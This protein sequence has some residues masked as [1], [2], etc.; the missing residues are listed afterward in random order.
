MRRLLTN[1]SVV[2]QDICTT[3]K[4]K[5]RSHRPIIIV[6]EQMP[7]RERDTARQFRDKAQSDYTHRGWL[8]GARAWAL[9]TITAVA[10]LH[11]TGALAADSGEEEVEKI[12][13]RMTLAEKLDYIG[14]IN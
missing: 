12:L 10:L 6:R 8:R 5:W 1:R 7:F 13:G 9:A 2:P 14:G 3:T 11:L 4:S